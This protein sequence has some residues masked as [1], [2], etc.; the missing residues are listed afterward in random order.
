MALALAGA[1]AACAPGASPSAS[2]APGSL[3]ALARAKGLRF[4]SA[5]GAGP[6][7]SLT[8]SFDD[9]RYREILLA[10]CGVLVPENELKWYVVRPDPR[11][12]SFERADRLVNFAV[13]HGMGFRGHTLLWHHPRWQP[14][15]VNSY[16]FGPN[17]RREAERLVTD[18]IRTVCGRYGDKIQSWDVVNETIDQATGARR[19]TVFSKHIGQE[20]VDLAFHTAREA[21]PRAQLVYNDY[22]N[23]EAFSTNHRAGVLRLLEHFKARNVPVDAL[24]VQSHIGSPND[25]GTTGF[26]RG[27]PREWRRFMDEVTG[28]GYDVLITEFDVHDA[29]VAGDILT[30][31]RAVASLAR[32]YLDLMFSYPQVK[33]V[34][35]WGMV[36]HYSWLQDRTKRADGLPARPTPYDSEYR[37]K[38]LRQ[39][40]ADAFRAAPPRT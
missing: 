22:M 27:D 19:E 26:D 33:Q 5:V 13:E 3:D 15:W 39:A 9:P 36:D 7:G 17:P 20:V 25:P 1:A 32:D 12:Y 18:Y 11:T 30:R 24:G 2:P 4:G 8:G 21:A 40:I 35:A 37:P 14:Q 29:G 34:L 28:M 38:L 23:W 16:D 6:Q 31:D 10:E